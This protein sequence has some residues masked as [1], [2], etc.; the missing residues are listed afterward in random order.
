MH[1]TATSLWDLS[2]AY[3]IAHTEHRVAQYRAAESKGIRARA[4]QNGTVCREKGLISH[5]ADIAPGD[6]LLRVLARQREEHLCAYQHTRPQYQ[7]VRSSMPAFSTSV[8]VRD[9][10]VSTSECVGPYRAE[11]GHVE[12]GNGVRE[13]VEEVHEKRC[14]F[15]LKGTLRSRSV[16]AAAREST[17]AS[18]CPVVPGLRIASYGPIVTELHIG[19]YGPAV[20]GA[21]VPE[22]APQTVPLYGARAEQ[23]RNS[24]TAIRIGR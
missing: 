12:L 1:S 7:R 15:A 10:P 11:F 2:T 5:L 22:T 4:V 24:R 3:Y 14:D 21:A 13:I 6:R 19:R 8:C 23:Y 17:F 18:Y 9:T 20:P 16:P